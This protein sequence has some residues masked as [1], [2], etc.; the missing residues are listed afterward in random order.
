MSITV[1]YFLANKN[2]F[3]NAK[4]LTVCGV[5]QYNFDDANGYQKRR[6]KFS[7]GQKSSIKG[8][9]NGK[10]VGSVADA[11]HVNSKLSEFTERAE[12]LYRQF[13]KKKNFP[14]T[15]SFR[16]KL[17]SDVTEVEEDR[18]FLND[19][20]NFIEDKAP[21]NKKEPKSSIYK[22][23]T[24][25]LNRIVAMSKAT[26]YDLDYSTINME[27]YNKFKKYCKEFEKED[28]TTGLKANTFGMHI[29]LLKT[30]LNYA[31]ANGWN[32]SEVYKL[33]AFAITSEEIEVVSLT[34]D[35]VKLVAELNLSDRKKDKDGVNRL[36]LSR[37]FFLLGCETGLRFSDYGK[38]NKKAIKQ[39]KGGY[40]LEIFRTQKT[41]KATVIP[42]S[43]LAHDILSKYNCELPEPP[44]NQKLNE[45][46]KTLMKLA[47]IDKSIS[48]HDARR[49]WCTIQYH[50]GFPVAWLMA[51]STHRT[52]R[53]FYSYIGVDLKENA[54]KVR[55]MHSKYQIDKKGLLNGNLRIA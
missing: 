2:K 46:I 15:I 31:K 28:G 48:T 40:N 19:F 37:D 13:Q 20:K 1:N 25:T 23:L 53:Q 14:T 42:L 41:K 35:E 11:S 6:F 36:A 49:T 47:E 54:D 34:E 38:I 43:Q 50:L 55:D 52:E 29:K 32:K 5:V 18:N 7:T 17:F 4:E 16:K 44:K 30:F 45:N 8:F 51:I 26:N 3:K 21:K 33:K 39:V 24:Q 9:K 10:V 12:K 22:N 27:F